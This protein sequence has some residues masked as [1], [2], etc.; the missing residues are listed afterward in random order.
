MITLYSFGRNFGLP[1]PSPFVTKTEV[2]LKM[3]GLPYRTDTGGFNKA[4]KGKLPYIDDAGTIVADSSLI[5]FHLEKAHGIDFDKGLAPEQKSVAWAMEKMCEE[6]LYWAI[7]HNRWI[8]KENFSKGPRT[9]F[10]KAPAPLRPIII[11]MINRQVRNTLKAQGLGRHAPG[12][13]YRLAEQDIDSLSAFLGAKTWF[14]GDHPCGSDASIWSMVTGALCPHFEG[15]IRT[16][17]QR[18][19]NLIAYRDRGMQRWYPELAAAPAT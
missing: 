15:R 4:P 7:V 17:A 19:D 18:H 1:D 16:A 5:R 13:I 6:H 8:E 14:G 3:S 9:F 2:H 10:D 11:A 12:D